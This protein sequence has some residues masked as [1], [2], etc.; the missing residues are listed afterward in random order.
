[1]DYILGLQHYLKRTL[2]LI[3]LWIAGDFS[4]NS[5][6]TTLSSDFFWS[7][8][9]TKKYLCDLIKKLLKTL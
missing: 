1:M 4:E 9:N 3:F 5:F 2:L 6:Y 7:I 8:T